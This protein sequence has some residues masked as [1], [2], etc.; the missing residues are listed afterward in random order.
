[1]SREELKQRL[2]AVVE[3]LPLG[4][5]HRLIEDA[6]YFLDWYHSKRQLRRQYRGKKIH[7]Y[8]RFD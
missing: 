8:R 5:L 7:R 6:H 1:V 2:D 3:Q 4:L